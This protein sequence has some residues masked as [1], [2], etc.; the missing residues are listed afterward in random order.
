MDRII[1]IFGKSVII[2]GRVC[3]EHIVL[4]DRAKHVR[5]TILQDEACPGMILQDGARPG[6]VLQDK[7]MFGSI[8][9][10]NNNMSNGFA[11]TE[12]NEPL[13]NHI[14]EPKFTLRISHE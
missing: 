5:E 6:T 2:E 1:Y 8:I 4:H 12:G 3:P 11:L 14:T 10:H 9:S 7:N 13:E